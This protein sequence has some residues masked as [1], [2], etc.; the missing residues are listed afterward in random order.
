MWEGSLFL[1]VWA[2]GSIM[3]CLSFLL[4]LLYF[5]F[6]PGIYKPYTLSD[7]AFYTIPII[8][9]IYLLTGWRHTDGNF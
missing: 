4:L 7:N 2:E 5:N 3:L 8:L 9:Y 1:V 6:V